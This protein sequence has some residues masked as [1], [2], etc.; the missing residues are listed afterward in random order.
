[1]FDVVGKKV[2]TVVNQ[3]LESGM[4]HARWDGADESGSKV[5]PGIYIYRFIGASR[6]IKTG[7]IIVN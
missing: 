6:L 7:K 4:H 5:S 1:V 3:T 2:K